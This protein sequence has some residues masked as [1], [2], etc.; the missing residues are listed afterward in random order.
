M[1]DSIR[2]QEALKQNKLDEEFIK[3]RLFHLELKSKLNERKLKKI[4]DQTSSDIEFRREIELNEFLRAQIDYY[5]RKLET[6]RQKL[7]DI[8][9]ENKKLNTDYQDLSSICE[10]S[11]FEIYKQVSVINRIKT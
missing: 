4:S 8:E 7:E 9:Q 2:L 3:R 5:R 6:T 1:V 10:S 11:F